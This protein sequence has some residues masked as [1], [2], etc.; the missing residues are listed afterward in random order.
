MLKKLDARTRNRENMVH[1]LGQLNVHVHY[2]DQRARLVLLV[3]AG[4][5]PSL[6]RRNWLH[7]IQLNW[8]KLQAVSRSTE[9][10]DLLRENNVLFKDEIGKIQQYEATLQLCPNAC[11]RF[12]KA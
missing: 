5:G 3:V 8:K 6:L 9:L 12:F 2:S 7:H 4:N 11:P 1:V 10:S